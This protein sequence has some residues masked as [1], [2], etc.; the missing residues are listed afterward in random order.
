MYSGLR[1]GYS[2]FG[3]MRK[4]VLSVSSNPQSRLVNDG[5]LTSNGFAVAP[6]ASVESALKKL[7]MLPF[8]AVVL[9]ASLSLREKK[10]FIAAVQGKKRFQVISLRRRGEAASGADV[11]IDGGDHHHVVGAIERFV[12]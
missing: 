12:S 11:E 5:V 6:A 10:R 8:S 2:Q 9:G 3:S 7:A 1:V 4:I